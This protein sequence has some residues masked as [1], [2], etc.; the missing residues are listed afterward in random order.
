MPCS[1]A[2]IMAQPLRYSHFNARMPKTRTQF[3]GEGWSVIAAGSH[4]YNGP[5]VKSEATTETKSV[6]NLTTT[7]IAL[8]R[9]ILLSKRISKKITFLYIFSFCYSSHKNSFLQKINCFAILSNDKI[10]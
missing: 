3:R 1:V 9:K 8:I 7:P 4:K 2:N 5:K 6:D 10:R